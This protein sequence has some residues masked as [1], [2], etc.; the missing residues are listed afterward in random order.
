MATTDAMSGDSIGTINMFVSRYDV[1]IFPI[2]YFLFIKIEYIK[3]MI[4]K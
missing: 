4:S 2:R 3:C 1:E